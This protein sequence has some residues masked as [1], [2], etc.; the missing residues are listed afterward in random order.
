MWKDLSASWAIL[1]GIGFMMLANGLQGTLL[2]VRAGIEGF[3]NSK[4]ARELFGDFFVDV[5]AATRDS[6]EREFRA[7]V[8][9]AERYRFF[10]LA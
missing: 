5:F 10:E 8:T 3:R 7:R 2:G 4:V 6:Q 1:L 9:Y